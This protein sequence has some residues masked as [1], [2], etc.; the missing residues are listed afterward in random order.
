MATIQQAIV[1]GS[2]SAL[3]LVKTLLENPMLISTE[4]PPFAISL[5][6]ENYRQSASADVADSLIIS[7]GSDTKKY[8][9][10]NVCPQAWQWEISGYIPGFADA[11]IVTWFMPFVALNRTLISK[12][13][14]KGSR[15]TFKDIHQKI[16][17]NVVIQSIEFTDENDCKNKQPFRMTLK[18]INTLEGDFFDE[19]GDVMEIA[20]VAVGTLEGAAANVGS[21]KTE[22]A[23]K[24]NIEGAA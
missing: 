5:E 22:D 1:S 6:V 23:S 7:T 18:K 3:N 10:D 2:A 11:E 4:N 17:T 24:A 13:F 19:F 9:S 12:A 20:Q 15:L 8:I 21:T 14:E 16:W